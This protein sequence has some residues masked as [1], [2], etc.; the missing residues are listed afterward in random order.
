[1]N[2]VNI[3]LSLSPSWFF[4]FCSSYGDSC[5]FSSTLSYNNGYKIFSN[6]SKG[7]LFISPAFYST[8]S[9]LQAS[10]LNIIYNGSNQLVVYLPEI[11]Q[12][13]LAGRGPFVPGFW[14][15]S[16]GS[17]HYYDSNHDGTGTCFSAIQ[18]MKPQHLARRSP[19]L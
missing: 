7:Y 18:A 19:L 6:F 4:S 16:D 9:T 10:T 11:K 3:S 13:N 8:P 17:T 2:S 12:Q 15:A 14:V 5:D 1:M